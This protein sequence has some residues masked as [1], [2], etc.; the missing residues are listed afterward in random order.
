LPLFN[1]Y[2]ELRPEIEL[3]GYVA[4]EFWDR[5]QQHKVELL[6]SQSKDKK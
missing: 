6:L 1:L 3:R 4:K 2:K 5:Y